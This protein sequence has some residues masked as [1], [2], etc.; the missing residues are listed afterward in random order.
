MMSHETQ[1]LNRSEQFDPNESE[2]LVSFK[3]QAGRP[4]TMYRN[5]GDLG[6]PAEPDEIEILKIETVGLTTDGRG[7]L[8]PS[9]HDI[10]DLITEAEFEYIE[11]SLF[12]NWQAEEYGIMAD[13][14][15]AEWRESEDK[16]D[17]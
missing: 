5:N 17:D 4:M 12:E 13:I 1:K 7:E 2:I 8:V 10:T 15:Y 16:S 14:E 11:T 3:Y 6:D 9:G